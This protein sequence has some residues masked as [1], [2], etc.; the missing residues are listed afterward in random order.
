MYDAIVIGGGATGTAIFR[1]LAL[2]GLKVGLIERGDLASGCTSNSHNNLV[3]GLRYVIKDPG[4]AM[5]CAIENEILREVAPHLISGEDNYWVG[6]DDDYTKAALKAAKRLGVVAE[7]LDIEKVYREI[8]A[9]APDFE[10]AVRSADINID[11][12]GLCKASLQ[13]GLEAL[14]GRYPGT[15]GYFPNDVIKS[16]DFR[17]GGLGIWTQRNWSFSTKTVV[18]ATGAWANSVLALLNARIGLTY[19]QGTIIVQETL[20]QRGLQLLEAPGDGQAYIVHNGMA[21]LGTTSTSISHPGEA[22]PEAKAEEA[23]KGLLGRLIPGVKGKRMERMFSGSRPL[24]SGEDSR[25]GRSISRDF[26]IVQKPYRV[27]TIVGGK[28]TLARLMAEKVADEI[29]ERL[30][31]TEPCITDKLVLPEVKL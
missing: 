21:W 23:L 19:N 7:P 10:I 11:A 29:A 20:S 13:Q 1:D 2:R 15:M 8:P 14:E 26:Q 24:Y 31:N 16:F 22:R 18:N 9:L 5:E 6:M 4:V 25:N 12:T 30:G 17:E 3:G 28:I 27:Y